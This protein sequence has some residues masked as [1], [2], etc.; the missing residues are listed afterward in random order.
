LCAL[1]RLRKS[2]ITRPILKILSPLECYIMHEKH[3]VIKR[4]VNPTRRST[5]T[6]EVYKWLLLVIEENIIIS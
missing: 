5:Q 1:N 4:R 2:E 3:E 6:N